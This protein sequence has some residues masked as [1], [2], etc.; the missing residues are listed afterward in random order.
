M[1]PVGQVMALNQRKQKRDGLKRIALTSIVLA[2]AASAVT[3]VAQDE[4]APNDPPVH[5]PQ[6][7]L[8]VKDGKYLSTI[9]EKND[10]YRDFRQTPFYQGLV[11]RIAPVIFAPADDHGTAKAAWQGR[12][13]EFL[14]SKLMQNR[15]VSLHVYRIS[16]L[17][18]PFVLS[19]HDL[20]SSELKIASNLISVLSSGKTEDYKYRDAGPV[21]VT[22]LL[23]KQQK[24]AVVIRDKCI[25]IGRDPEAVASSSYTCAKSASMVS[26]AE[27][28]FS[29]SESFPALRG[30]SEKFFGILPRAKM[31]LKWDSSKA[32][33]A[34]QSAKVDLADHLLG[35]GKVPSELMA[36]IPSESLFFA[37]GSIPNPKEGFSPEGLAK[38]FKQPKAELRKG[39]SLPVALVYVPVYGENVTTHSTALL[40]QVSKEKSAATVGQLVSSFTTQKPETFVRVVCADLVAVSKDAKVFDTLDSVCKKQRPA[41]AQMPKKWVDST[42]NASV[43]GVAYLNPG[44]LFSM[45]IERGWKKSSG[46]ASAPY[47]AEI[48]Q[49]RGM[50]EMLPAYFFVGAADE[51]TMTMKAME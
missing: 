22:A 42:Q 21:K 17:T 24:F 40:I 28:D 26:D 41:I 3:A 6:F 32:R 1:E 48:K 39:P 20:S 11:G 50:A 46:K 33:F 7:S 35:K 44:K 5:I 25:S 8:R 13:I 34:V 9:T 45:Q 49:A 36:A 4:N 19:V 31:Q 51:K 18:S 27:V 37:L 16:N 43:A 12:L 38:Y 10:W 15:P 2:I 14:Y 23:V 30:V 29:L 47:A